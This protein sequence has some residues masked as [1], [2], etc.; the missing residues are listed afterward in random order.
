MKLTLK[1]WRQADTNA[2]EALQ[3]YTLNDISTEMYL[4][5]TRDILK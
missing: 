1:I 4:L 5:E 2:H 3:T